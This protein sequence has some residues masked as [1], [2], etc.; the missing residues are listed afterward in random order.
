LAGG[1]LCLFPDL[2]SSWAS[3]SVLKALQKHDITASANPE[4]SCEIAGSGCG[5]G[6]AWALYFYNTEFF[7][8]MIE[9]NASHDQ[10]KKSN[11]IF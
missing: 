2:C 4:V 9:G 6:L 7:K 11:S 8:T 3:F 10:R 5:S 1:I